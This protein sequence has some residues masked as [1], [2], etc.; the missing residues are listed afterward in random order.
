MNALVI[1][2]HTGYAPDGGRQTSK[3][4]VRLTSYYLEDSPLR[5]S[6]FAFDINS[7]TYA[8][9]FPSVATHDPFCRQRSDENL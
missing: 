4:S 5:S 2:L 1:L 7:P 6:E 9:G 3:P 8:G